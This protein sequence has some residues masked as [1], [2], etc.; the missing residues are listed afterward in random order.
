M[1]DVT[2]RSLL[3]H[4]SADWWPVSVALAA[5]LARL[6]LYFLAAPL[7]ALLALPAVFAVSTM[8]AAFNHHHQHVNVGVAQRMGELPRGREGV[9]RD[10][11]RAE[12]ERAEGERQPLRRVRQQE[13]DVR[14]FDDAQGGEGA[15]GAQGLVAEL[16]VGHPPII[17]EQC[18]AAFVSS[19]G[20]IEQRP[21]AGHATGAHGSVWYLTA[22]GIPSRSSRAAR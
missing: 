8:I 11:H 19:G 7:W 15:R 2:H 3:L 20:G 12:A 9:E 14:A 4:Y 18:G 13:A 1:S 5:F 22:R 17:M 6:A 16:R 10:Q 21:D